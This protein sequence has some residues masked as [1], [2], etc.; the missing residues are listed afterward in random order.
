M[1]K[2]VSVVNL[3]VRFKNEQDAVI[4]RF[5]LRVNS[6][7]I[8]GRLPIVDMFFLFFSWVGLKENA[9][10]SLVM[11]LL[12]LWSVAFQTE[13]LNFRLLDGIVLGVSQSY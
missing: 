6:T 3:E 12:C 7:I 5:L 2:V 1:V 9:T 11:W 8:W 13:W 10:R 4:V